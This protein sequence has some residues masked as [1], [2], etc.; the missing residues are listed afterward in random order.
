ME[1][2]RGDP[3]GL[4]E[5]HQVAHGSSSGRE[6]YQT[7]PEPAW[8]L[9]RVACQGSI[10]CRPA[11]GWHERR[12]QARGRGG[13]REAG[14]GGAESAEPAKQPAAEEPEASEPTASEPAAASE[15]PVPVGRTPATVDAPP[16]ADPHDKRIL[17]L[18]LHNLIFVGMILGVV[19]GLIT[20]SIDHADVL[21][22]TDG[23]EV[24]GD[25]KQTGDL[26]EVLLPSG[27]AETYAADQVASVTEAA[28]TESGKLYANAVWWLNLF[29]TTLF[30][31]ALKMLIAPLIFASIVAGVVSLP[32]IEHLK[33]IGLKTF[34]YYCGTT[35]CAVT[36]GLVAVLVIQPGNKASSDKL[37]ERRA[38]EL[39]DREAQ[40]QQ[41]KGLPV[42]LDAPGEDGERKATSDFL[43]WLSQAEAQKAGTGHDADLAKRLARAEDLTPGEMF[44]S[45]LIAPMLTNPFESLAKAESLGLIAFA[46][47]LGIAVVI[48]GEPAR[49]V[50][51]FFTAF[52]EVILWI[53]KKLMAFAP[54][55]VMC[56]VAELL[57]RNGTDVFAPLAWYCVT[58]LVGIGI[59]VGLLV[60]IAATV[61]GCSP[62]RLW[63]GIREAWMIAF[64]TRSS[65]A[66]LPVT[67]RCVNDN[68]GVSP[69]VSNFALPV[70]ATMNMDGTALY[71]GIAVIFILQIYQNMVDVPI[72]L[73]GVVTLIIF[74]TAVLAS[75]GA[76]AVPD[77]GLITMVLVATAIGLPAYY[78][79]IIYAVDAFL[80]MFR[81]STNVLGDTV[82]C[83]VVDNLE[84][85]AEAKLAA[86]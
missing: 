54:F 57:A 8:L 78:I 77:A 26:Y 49:P 53:T 47:L 50:A 32:S 44:K 66:T 27:Q 39:A 20:Y 24:L 17:G 29:G 25:V 34:V 33:S 59:H 55:C 10:K 80:D 85:K 70:G 37:R 52:N 79:P 73:G 61:G 68:L 9:A 58:V 48:V 35:A 22:L 82:G 64:T 71:E 30:M 23:T 63:N 65:A 18:K 46:V 11:W 51:E 28:D 15:L 60:T 2:D 75:V 12:R 36:I 42:Y 16:P 1:G 45:N 86:A 62:S 7:A 41:E 3:L 5:L 38:A 4:L 76:A 84:R 13:G 19:L 6:L 67:M 40:Y 81:T 72:E 43:L 31:R 83:V 74:V 14:A 56:L 21:K 69:K